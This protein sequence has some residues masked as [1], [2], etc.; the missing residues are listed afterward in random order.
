MKSNDAGPTDTPVLEE[1]IGENFEPAARANRDA[2][3][4]LDVVCDR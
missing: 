2:E 4:V 3:A 1:T